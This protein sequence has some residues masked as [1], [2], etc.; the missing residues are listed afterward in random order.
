MHYKTILILTAVSAVSARSVLPLKRADPIPAAA[1]ANATWPDPPYIPYISSPPGW[2]NAGCYSDS[3]TRTLAN[4]VSVSSPFS[5][6][7]C[8]AAC[9]SAGYSYAGV[10]NGNECYCSNTVASTGLKTSDADCLIPCA[11]NDAQSCGGGWRV[12]IFQKEDHATLNWPPSGWSSLGCYTDSSTRTLVG[13][14]STF[15]NMA[16]TTDCIFTCLSTGYKFAGIENGNECYCSNAVAT[17]GVPASGA[18]C[19]TPCAGY[20]SNKCGGGWRLDIYWN[21]YWSNST[22]TTS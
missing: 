6:E 9:D 2:I 3:W 19:S 13:S 12:N 5:R 17:T 15:N 16:S 7:S 8:I 21:N 14:S 11:G 20:P 18:D 4:S 10:E 22:T 1:V